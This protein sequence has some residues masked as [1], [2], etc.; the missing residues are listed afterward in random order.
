MKNTVASLAATV[1]TLL[2][3]TVSLAAPNAEEEDLALVYGDK[4]TVSIATGSPQPLQRAPSTATVITA[5]D[6]A[7]MGAKDLDEVLET[8][9]GVHVERSYIEYTPMYQ[10]RGIVGNPTNPQVLMLQNGISIN[11]LFRGDR[12]QAWGGLPLDNIARIEVIRGPGSALY[13]AD[14][15]AGVINI[16]TKTAKDIDGTKIGARGGSFATWNT[17]AQHGGKWGEVEVAAYV[18]VGATDGFKKTI[19]EDS[20]TSRDQFFGTHVSEAPGPVNT[21][22]DSVDAN[23]DLAYDKWRLRSGYKLRDNLGMGVGQTATLDPIGTE[24][25]ERINADLSWNDAQ[26]AKNWGLGFMASFLHYKEDA[27]N[28]HMFPAGTRLGPFNYPDGM[29]GSPGRW[30]RQIRISAFANYTGFTDHNLRIGWGHDDLN[31]YKTRTLKNF[32]LLPNGLPMPTGA[33]TDYGSIQPHIL[34]HTRIDDYFYLQDEWSFAPDWTLTAGVRYDSYSDFGAT[35]NPRLAMVWNVDLDLTA[36]FLWG[37]A[38]RAPSFNEQYGINPSGGGNPGLQPETMDT[39]EVDISWQA[40]RDTEVNLSFFQYDLAQIIS[41]VANPAPAPGLAFQ[42]TGKQYG[43][44]LELETTWDATSSLRLTGNYS[45]QTSIDETHNQDAGYMPH[46]HVYARSDWRFMQ[47]WLASVQVNWVGDRKRAYGDARPPIRDY[48]TIDL[49]LRTDNSKKGWDFA[50]S[51]RNLF[52]ATVLEP[53]LAPGTSLPYDLPMPGRS[54]YLQAT[55]S[56]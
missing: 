18:N 13:G 44:G 5:E 20:Q 49:T 41:A 31:L 33:V 19:I 12:G 50:A 26:F 55:F 7:A 21:G 1:P 47:P 6:I 22:Y 32:F 35:V 52:D 29:I 37:R 39:Y 23:L 38:F 9:P 45:F 53:S 56:F 30:E 27:N 11:T 48:T 54:F 17:W 24:T 14:A 15:Y 3:I 28:Y 34:P 40:R 51:I 46:H 36:K 16:I 25:S 4:N 42:N 43:R 2:W 10:F 8:V